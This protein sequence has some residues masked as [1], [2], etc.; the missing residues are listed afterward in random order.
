[1]SAHPEMIGSLKLPIYSH[2]IQSKYND[3]HP[4]AISLKLLHYLI[5]VLL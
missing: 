5:G 3:E 1:M 2:P 4:T